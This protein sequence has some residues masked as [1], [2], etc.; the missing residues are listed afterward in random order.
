VISYRKYWKTECHFK[1]IVGNKIPLVQSL[2]PMFCFEA[3]ATRNDKEFFK[4]TSAGVVGIV[5]K[6]KMYENGEC[7]LG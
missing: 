2:M 4:I 6:F 3:L 5:P 7:T 1:G